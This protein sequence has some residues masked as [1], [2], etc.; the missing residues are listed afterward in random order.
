MAYGLFSSHSRLH[1]S[2]SYR[3]LAQHTPHHTHTLTPRHPQG[4]PWEYGE[5][6][7]KVLAK[8][9]DAKHRLMPY[10]YYHAIQG[11]EKGH[12][13][14]RAMWLDFVDDRTTHSLDRQFMLG[15]SLLV[16]P[17]FVPSSEE[18]EYYLPGGRWTS[19]WS[20]RII[21]GPRWVREKVAVDDIP[22]WVRPGTI[23]VLGQRGVKTPDYDYTKDLTVRIYEIGE[24]QSVASYIPRGSGGEIAG[25]IRARRDGGGLNIW[26]AKGPLT[27]ATIQIF[28]KDLP[29]IQNVVGAKQR[30]GEVGI[31]DVDAGTREVHIQT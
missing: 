12:P 26:V 30:N 21:E 7:P 5:D 27:V 8:Y 23:L 14:Q 2:H 18:A 20:D 29:M 9:L 15:P 17:V 25:I 24:G 3:K 19:F 28:A 6:A 16:A 10:L 11:H 4:V 13:V 31:F 22:V 1:G